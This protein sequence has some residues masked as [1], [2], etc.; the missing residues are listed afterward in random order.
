MGEVC[1]AR[2]GKL[3]RDVALSVFPEAFA[4]DA[5]RMVRFDRDAQVLTALN[6]PNICKLDDGGRITWSW[7]THNKGNQPEARQYSP[8]QAGSKEAGKTSGSRCPFAEHEFASQTR[9]L[10]YH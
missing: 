6:H 1:R 9:K 4:R 8:D 3:G 5:D 10:D 2:D 7:S